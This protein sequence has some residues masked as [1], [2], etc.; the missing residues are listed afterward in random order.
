MR[1]P[2][3]HDSTV[4]G[5]DA[6][7]KTTVGVAATRA[8]RATHD[9]AR[10]MRA[11]RTPT[12][13][14]KRA[15]GAE[16]TNSPDAR[17]ARDG[18]RTTTPND[19]KTRAMSTP[20]GTGAVTPRATL[21][22]RAS[23]LLRDQRQLAS[24]LRAAISPT[25]PSSMVKSSVKSSES[26]TKRDAA[27]L[28][29]LNSM[30]LKQL[31]TARSAAAEA[32]SARETLGE[33]MAREVAKS[34]TLAK[35][36]EDK[37]EALRA[38]AK[39]A[40]KESKDSA[41]DVKAEAE[42]LRTLNARLMKEVSIARAVV[43]AREHEEATLKEI[44]GKSDERAN[45]LEAEIDAKQRTLERVQLALVS[46]T[47]RAADSLRANMKVEKLAETNAVLMGELAALRESAASDSQALRAQIAAKS[48]ALIEAKAD[49]AAAEDE[50]NALSGAKSD[51][52][53][54][55]SLNATLMQQI[56]SLR[57]KADEALDVS[58]ALEGKER[59]LAKVCDDLKVAEDAKSAAEDDVM[60]LRQLNVT[61]LQQI[62]ALKEN[63]EV[64]GAALEAK[65]S[66]LEA[67]QMAL[68]LVEEEQ[69][70]TQNDVTKL[71]ELNTVIMSQV[72]TL[73][74]SSLD[75]RAAFK[76][77]MD[78]KNAELSRARVEL[79]RLEQSN[80]T[81]ESALEKARMRQ[82]ALDG[83][84]TTLKKIAE[85][86]MATNA[87]LTGQIEAKKLELADVKESLA[88]AEAKAA[89]LEAAEYDVSKLRELNSVLIAQVK[90]LRSVEAENA[91]LTAALRSRS[92]ELEKAQ[93]Q[94]AA[95]ERAKATGEKVSE[96]EIANLREL[97]TRII[98]R[99]GEVK[100]E[101]EKKFQQLIDT[102][103]L[104]LASVKA[105]LAEATKELAIGRKD[106]MALEK[107]LE[108]LRTMN[109][110]LN[111]SIKALEAEIEGE[112]KATLEMRQA[113]LDAQAECA[114]LKGRLS[115]KDDELESAWSAL[116]CVNADLKHALHD[117]TGMRA[118]AEKRHGE[119]EEAN[120]NVDRLR[121]LNHMMIERLHNAKK[122]ALEAEALNA[123]FAAA[124]TQ[125]EVTVRSEEAKV[126]ALEQ[127]L[128]EKDEEY[129]TT[130]LA[131]RAEMES[132]NSASA[133]RLA[134]LQAQMHSQIH[135]LERQLEYA[136]LD[137]QKVQ[138]SEA[139]HIEDQ[140]R[141][142]EEIESLV[143]QLELT[144]SDAKK[145]ANAMNKQIFA[146][147]SKVA[148][149]EASNKALTK[150]LNS[151]KAE[152]KALEQKLADAQSTSSKRWTDLAAASRDLQEA[153]TA[154][155]V[156]DTIIATMR[157][158]L[159]ELTNTAEY[160]TRLAR[161]HGEEAKDFSVK[162]SQAEGQ[163][164]SQEKRIGHLCASLEETEIARNELSQKVVALERKGGVAEM[165]IRAAAEHL[166][167]ANERAR[168]LEHQLKSERADFERTQ[169][170][171]TETL[172]AAERSMEANMQ[173]ICD[174][175]AKYQETLQLLLVE[176]EHSAEVRD[177]MRKELQFVN[178]ELDATS[179]DLETMIERN[180]SGILLKVADN[181]MC[182]LVFSAAPKISARG[183]KA[184]IRLGMLGSIAALI[185]QTVRQ[186]KTKVVDKAT[187]QTPRA[188]F[189]FAFRG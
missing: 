7:A 41:E 19:A 101:Q 180:N 131:L 86:N 54:L 179:A 133:Q 67:A 25:R 130:T 116:M 134:N 42:R 103:T 186:L 72:K 123:E 158:E 46:A 16:V 93:L 122:A 78:A 73:K 53:N 95:A 12:T 183:V 167:K 161:E 96:S 114:S 94:L 8:R 45:A 156:K 105:E 34:K 2:T 49:L 150:K 187:S 35:D 145:D 166:Y 151:S 13:M 39:R 48:D 109:A 91:S 70:R 55:R 175:E 15:F 132:G 97:N 36:V 120:V 82:A 60:K 174:L 100:E 121:E 170:A 127:K 119:L 4:R 85:E 107:S 189:R 163:V 117:A 87:H 152:I 155:K 43:K 58:R 33:A 57:F 50:V 66:E 59:E 40:K 124:R 112:K 137:L 141:S 5:L 129:A 28:R 71:R 160:F 6:D 104:E 18:G 23:A 26:A 142:A 69:E 128:K 63:S 52:D 10:A 136:N 62:S 76:A 168:S 20:R 140:R 31:S 29:E 24:P 80:G 184:V 188:S 185:G 147:Q 113:I 108:K 22:P 143:A 153:F 169:A 83:E 90:T 77:D 11:N 125:A 92:A 44:A 154:N 64:D 37:A 178:E 176:R 102:K 38:A 165:T 47:E 110:E 182:K 106:A 126:A 98:Q 84:V 68:E 159:K 118:L 56:K 30:L 148:A 61:L 144:E 65:Q 74:K 135:S 172:N 75:D 79:A 27:R 171:L 14:R 146:L 138:R 162:L 32:E 1:I 17:D 139:A 149:H 164:V 157:T 173:I 99:M 9:D 177:E 111:G 21:T 89:K 88:T 115:A 51:V 3:D 181:A 81:S